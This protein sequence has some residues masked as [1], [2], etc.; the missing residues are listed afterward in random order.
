MNFP[1]GVKDATRDRRGVGGEKR[2]TAPV[3]VLMT[4]LEWCAL[5]GWRSHDT[6]WQL[7][8]SS[9]SIIFIIRSPT[10]SQKVRWVPDW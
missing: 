4:I 9:G 10:V 7:F 1:S 5:I 6:L 3:G 2:V 8:S